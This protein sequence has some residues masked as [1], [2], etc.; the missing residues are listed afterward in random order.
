MATRRRRMGRRSGIA[1]R[2]FIGWKGLII[3]YFA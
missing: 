1:E 2:R 3:A